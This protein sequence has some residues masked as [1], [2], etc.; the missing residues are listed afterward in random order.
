MRRSSKPHVLHRH[1]ETSW[2][3]N[4]HWLNLK[5]YWSTQGGL[6]KI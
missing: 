2:P 1:W 4:L 6:A 5:A 3:P